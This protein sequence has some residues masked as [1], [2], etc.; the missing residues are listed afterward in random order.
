MAMSKDA[1]IETVYGRRGSGKSTL[2]KGMIK[3]KPKLVAFDPR[4]EYGGKGWVRC[5]TVKAVK[6]AMGERWWKGFKISYV[7]DAGDEMACLSR[8]CELLWAAQS[9]YETGEDTRKLTLVVEE[10]DLSF[11]SRPMPRDQSWMI[12]VCNQGRHAGIEAIAVTQRPAQLN[13]AFR[14]NAA[15][16]FCFALAWPEDQKAFLRM[17]P[18]IDTDAFKSLENFRFVR[19]ENGKISQHKISKTGK[20]S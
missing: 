18:G 3:G 20:I 16:T 10:A 12:R 17:A 1:E 9:V 5:R 2:T 8:L 7:P 13:M 6:K 15:R 14:G 19:L 4:A 11:P